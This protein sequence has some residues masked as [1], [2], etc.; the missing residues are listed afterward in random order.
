MP[1]SRTYLVALEKP[2]EIRP[3]TTEEAER[4]EETRKALKEAYTARK[5]T[6]KGKKRYGFNPNAYEHTLLTQE[7]FAEFMDQCPLWA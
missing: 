3:L 6:P 2:K 5:T 4:F 7:A 1:T